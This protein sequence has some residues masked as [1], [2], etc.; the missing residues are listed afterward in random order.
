MSAITKYLINLTWAMLLCSY[1]HGQTLVSGA[2]VLA[3]ARLEPNYTLQSEHLAYLDAHRPNL[4]YLDQVSLRTETDRFDPDRQEYA[5]RFSMNSLSEVSKENTLQDITATSK[6]EVQRLYLHE[7]LLRR[8][9]GLASY[10]YLVQR[11]AVEKQLAD[12][13]AGRAGVLKKKGML[14]LDVDVDELIKNDF[15]RDKL[16]LDI[17]EDESMLTYVVKALQTASPS[18]SGDW[19]PDTTGFINIP[20]ISLQLSQWSDSVSNHPQFAIKQVKS[21][22]LD[23]EYAVERAKS[24]QILDFVQLRYA[25]VPYVQDINRELSVGLSLYLPFNGGSHL[26]MEELLVEKNEAEQ[27]M[28]LYQ[29]DMTDRIQQARLKI[30]V[31]LHQYE[32]AQ[33]QLE[34]SGDRFILDP[35]NVPMEEGAVIVLSAREL[36]LKRQL[37]LLTIED[38]IFEQYIRLLDLTGRLSASPAVNYLSHELE[39]Y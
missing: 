21:S 37:N 22:V 8:Y 2:Q 10:Y 24:N 31:L 18:I 34:A 17:A 26:K 19:V 32:V 5:I 36:Q 14:D 16:D 13:Y 12:V 3:A 23:A 38:Q 39:T 1:G 15:D 9:Q 28:L 25:N 20:L 6:A 35:G 11:L 7:S 4:P 27:N 33:K 30:E 29:N